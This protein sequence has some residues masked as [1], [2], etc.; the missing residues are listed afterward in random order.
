MDAYCEKSYFG[1][2]FGG[3]F[4]DEFSCDFSVSALDSNQ[5]GYAI[6]TGVYRVA[7]IRVL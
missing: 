3:N 2:I 4:D 1:G 7:G 5:A 6:P